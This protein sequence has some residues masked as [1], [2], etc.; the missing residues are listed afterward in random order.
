MATVKIDTA[1]LAEI[2]KTIA[3]FKGAD[4]AIIR[5]T[6]DALSGV[7]T[8][9]AKLIGA[10]VTAKAKDIKAHFSI[11][12]MFKADMTADVTCSGK[13]LALAKYTATSVN[14]GVSAKVLKAKGKTTIKHAF[15]AKMKSGHT[16]VYWRVDER[17]GRVWPTAKKRQVQP[18]ATGH[19]YAKY[20]LK[21]HELY[22][23][24][25]S[26]IYDDPDIINPVLADANLRLQARL[27]YHTQKMIEKAR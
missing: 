16:G 20:R 5:A 7:Q 17:R 11:K 18:W 19:K 3:A 26:E 2:Q 6:N 27:E 22:G 14:A 15:I 4:L 13:A 8:Q 9:S 24:P 25:I 10:K 23:P 1:D 12:K 21:I